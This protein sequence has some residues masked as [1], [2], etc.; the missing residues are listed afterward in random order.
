MPTQSSDNS[1]GL[2]S[3]VAE[4]A[5]ATVADALPFP[6]WWL[7]R[8]AAALLERV[9]FESARR[10]TVTAVAFI[11]ARDAVNDLIRREMLGRE[12][13]VVER[14]QNGHAPTQPNCMPSDH[15]SD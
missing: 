10:D 5:P 6:A 8:L 2:A 7:V 12:S 11:R 13:D 9:A 3:P 14:P 15:R 4:T 1:A